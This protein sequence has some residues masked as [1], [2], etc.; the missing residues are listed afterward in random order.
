MLGNHTYSHVDLT[1]VSDRRFFTELDRTQGLIRRFAGAATHWLR[2]PYG[3]VNSRVR[4]L[5]GRR[6][7]RVAVWDVDPQDWR[8]PGVSSIVRNVLANTDPGDVV[9]MH[10]GG[11]DRSQTVAALARILE[12][13]RG[14][15]Y[16]FKALP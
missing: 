15:G 4:A 6:G 12:T 10:D 3:A 1:R 8:R 9:L 2:P 13:M 16:T 5:A 7:Y 11:G 14:R